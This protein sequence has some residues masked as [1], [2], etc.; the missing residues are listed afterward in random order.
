[1]ITKVEIAH[2]DSVPTVVVKREGVAQ[3]HLPELFDATFARFH[4]A[5]TEGLV[6]PSGPAVAMYTRMAE[7]LDVEIGFPGQLAE[8]DP[9]LTESSLPGGLIARAE[10]WGGYE[11]LPLAW[12]E[13][14][15]DVAAQGHEPAGPCWELYVTQPTPDMNP[16]A[17]R[18]DLCCVVA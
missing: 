15:K 11:G 1:M 6:Q 7:T 13:F 14:V 5:I 2:R 4:A 8:A 12:A 9:N 17:L 3:Q 18:T 10:Y 16:A